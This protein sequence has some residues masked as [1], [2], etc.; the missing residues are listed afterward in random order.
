MAQPSDSEL[1]ALDRKWR[2][3]VSIAVVGV[4][5]SGVLLGVLIIPVV[6][7]RS[8]GIDAYT[9]LAGGLDTRPPANSGRRQTGARS[10]QGAGSLRRLPW[11]AGRVG[12]AAVS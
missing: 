11:R 10:C 4:L 1:S 3:W 6:Q 5:L 7:G 2:T 8:D 12:G 9:G